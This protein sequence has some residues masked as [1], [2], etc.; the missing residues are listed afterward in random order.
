MVSGTALCSYGTVARVAKWLAFLASKT[1]SRNKVTLL[2]GCT[3]CVTCAACLNTCNE[4]IA[5]QARRTHTN[6]SVKINLTPSPGATNC[7]EAR[8]Y[9]FLRL[10]SLVQR[11]ITVNLTL[12]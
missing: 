10:A 9:T 8:I 3:V 2:I 12:I 1:G 7:G 11:T 5:L 4:W 6:G